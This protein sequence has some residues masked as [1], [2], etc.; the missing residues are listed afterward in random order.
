MIYLIEYISLYIAVLVLILILKSLL[1]AFY[2]RIKAYLFPI[3]VLP[4]DI[5]EA[6]YQEAADFVHSVHRCWPLDDLYAEYLNL[7]GELMN[8]KWHEL[9]GKK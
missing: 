4:D 5:R 1:K 6:I 8:K 7:S 9:Y 3:P 2:I